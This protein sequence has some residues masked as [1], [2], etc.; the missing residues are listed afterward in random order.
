VASVL[1]VDD[2][3]A[4]RELVTLW[5]C[6]EGFSVR[7]AQDGREALAQL[8]SETVDIAIVDVMMP[9]LDG[10]ELCRAIR[11]RAGPPVL[12]LTARGET[13]DKVRGLSLGADDYLVKPFDPPELVARVRAVLRRYRINT[14]Q[15]ATIGALVLDRAAHRATVDGRDVAL[16]P[17]EFELL[18]VLATYPGQTLSR[19][20]LIEEIWGYAY[21]G[22][23]RTVDVHVGR[24]RAHFPETASGFRIRA[25][26]GLG[27]RLELAP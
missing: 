26:R 25:V 17:K 13:A 24:L 23:E 5:L 21:D 6:R 27:Y 3:L 10:W 22:D 8:D 14:A 2:D 7:E 19:D 15:T 18:F 1:V 20:R 4:L 16:P 11:E 12:M 9:H